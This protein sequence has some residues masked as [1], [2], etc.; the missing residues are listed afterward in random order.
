MRIGR[1]REQFENWLDEWKEHNWSIEGVRGWSPFEFSDG[2]VNDYVRQ[3]LDT[4]DLGG[5]PGLSWVADALA[6]QV[7]KLN[8][9]QALLGRELAI[10]H[11]AGGSWSEVADWTVIGDGT[12]RALAK[13]SRIRPRGRRSHL[14]RELTELISRV[15]DNPFHRSS[16]LVAASHFLRRVVKELE[17]VA[18]HL[19]AELDSAGIARQQI[20]RHAKI[21]VSTLSNKL[22]RGRV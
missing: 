9:C 22:D 15:P 19:C 2:D 21:T 20:A 5:L 10:L 11:D 6:A 16:Q 3:I 12:V 4:A 8:R 1:R 14:D 17:Y 13:G 7:E 18:D